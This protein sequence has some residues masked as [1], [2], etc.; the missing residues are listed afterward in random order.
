MGLILDTSVIVTA[1]RRGQS[2]PRILAQ[3][4]LQLGFEVVTENVRH[5]QMIPRLVVKQI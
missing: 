3:L 2:V 4:A 5:F 1:E